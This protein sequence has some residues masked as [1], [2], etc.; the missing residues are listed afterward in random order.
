MYLFGT[1]LQLD[2]LLVS[3]VDGEANASVLVVGHSEGDH[4]QD[5]QVL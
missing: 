5:L 2:S 4:T 3:V 1:Y